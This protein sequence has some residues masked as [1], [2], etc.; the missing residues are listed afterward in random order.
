MAGDGP[1]L[2]MAPAIVMIP[3]DE[4]IVLSMSGQLTKGHGF[5]EKQSVLALRLIKKYQS[6]LSL[7]L[8]KDIAPFVDNPTFKMPIRVVDHEKKLSIIEGSNNTKKIAAQF[9]YNEELIQKVRNFKKVLSDHGH[10]YGKFIAPEF[11]VS[12]DEGKRVWTMPLWEDTIEWI[13][14]NLVPLNFSIDEELQKFINDGK[15]IEKTIENYVP[16]LVFEENKFLFKNTHK[17]IP[18]PETDDLLEALFFAQD[19]GIHT[20]DEKIDKMLDSKEIN[21]V[22]QHFFKSSMSKGCLL[23]NEKYSLTDLDDVLKHKKLFLFLIPGGSELANLKYCYNT[24]TE[25]GISQE[26][27]SVLFRLD[28]QTGKDFNELIK[29]FKLNNP[30][31]EN[32]K[33]IFVSGKIPKT[34]ISFYRPID[35]IINLGDNSAHYTQKNLVKNHH[36][37]I[38]YNIRKKVA[39]V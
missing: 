6:Y 21:P 18:Q 38:N 25:M 32:T 36:C 11:T 10:G 22:T 23:D 1:F 4:K 39:N 8:N 29:M 37:V 24:L 7:A 14:A 20:W 15:D 19:Y 2:F 27:M 35:V 9:P 34:L 5:T 13:N 16:M 26:N 3:N 17:N 30:L 28:N 12:W 33:V 31:G